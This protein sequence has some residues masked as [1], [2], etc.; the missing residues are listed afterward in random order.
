MRQRVGHQPGFRSG[1][2]GAQRRDDDR[3]A[4]RMF[5]AVERRLRRGVLCC[6]RRVGLIQLRDK[7]EAAPMDGADRRLRRAVVAKRKPRGVNAAG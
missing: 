5:G 1:A 3:W 4:T 6:G 7:T 2:E